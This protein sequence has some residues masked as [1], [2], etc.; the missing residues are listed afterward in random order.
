MSQGVLGKHLNVKAQQ[1]H[2]YETGENR[3]SAEAIQQCSEI[4]GVPVNYFYGNDAAF[5]VSDLDKN[6][7]SI[8]SELINFD[9]KVRKD[10]QKLVRTLKDII[11]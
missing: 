8:V 3:L 2:K 9:P 6:I 7:M 1:V 4:F 11:Q 5:N 10:I